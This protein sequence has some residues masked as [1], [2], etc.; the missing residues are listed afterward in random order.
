MGGQDDFWARCSPAQT[1]WKNV[2]INKC[3]LKVLGWYV[4]NLLAHH[5]AAQRVWIEYQSHLLNTAQPSIIFINWKLNFTPNRPNP[6][7]T[8]V[9]AISPKDG[10]RSQEPHLKQHRPR[11]T[12]R[13]ADQSAKNIG[14]DRQQSLARTCAGGCLWP[15]LNNSVKLVIPPR[16]PAIGNG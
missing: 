15:D 5:L 13:N 16:V 14:V 3:W 7:I 9:C 4:Y 1:S 11:R 6:T 2:T 10:L 12:G 8:S